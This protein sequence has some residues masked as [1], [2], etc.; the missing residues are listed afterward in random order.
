MAIS[1]M[2]LQDLNNERKTRVLAVMSSCILGWH[3]LQ[4]QE[5]RC[6]EKSVAFWDGQ[7]TGGYV[8]HFNSFLVVVK[9]AMVLRKCKL[10]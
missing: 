4:N 5:L 7:I 10:A 1:V 9:D 8:T 2:V 3:T 6:S